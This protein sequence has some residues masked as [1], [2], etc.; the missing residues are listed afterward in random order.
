MTEPARK[1]RRKPRPLRFAQISVGDV[2]IQR[3][4]T[5][6]ALRV[7]RPI[8]PA[9]D[10]PQEPIYVPAIATSFAVVTDLWFDPV[11]GQCEDIDGQM[12]GFQFWVDGAGVGTKMSDNRRGL[13]R[14]GWDFATPD[15][16]ADAQGEYDR[17]RRRRQA[18]RDGEVTP[19]R[20]RK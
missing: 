19:I 5:I 6:R 7:A 4:K 20:G 9:N 17:E 1:R 13:Q 10:D 2:L 11:Y 15:Q 12:V 14:R 3:R 18:V 8:K 16:I